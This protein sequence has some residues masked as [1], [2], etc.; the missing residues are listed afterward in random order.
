MKRITTI[1]YTQGRLATD[2]RIV[3]SFVSFLPL[4]MEMMFGQGA[5]SAQPPSRQEQMEMRKAQRGIT[6]TTPST[7]GGSEDDQP[8]PSKVCQQN[9]FDE[10]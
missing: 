7:V 10:E 4:L 2:V 5:L 9:R 8:Y 3:F 6:T 1:V